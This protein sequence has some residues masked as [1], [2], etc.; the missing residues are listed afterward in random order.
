MSVVFSNS[1]G[2]SNVKPRLK[3]T[4]LNPRYKDAKSLPKMHIYTKLGL[5][6]EGA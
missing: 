1:L 5:V 6:C 4:D 3:S 2:D